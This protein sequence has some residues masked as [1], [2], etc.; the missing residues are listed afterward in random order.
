[1]H[2]IDDSTPGVLNFSEAHYSVCESE[3]KITIT[4]TRQHGGN[5]TVSVK[6]KTVDREAV[7]PEDYE[8][9]DEDEPLVRVSH[10]IKGFPL[11]RCGILCMSCASCPDLAL[12]LSLKVLEF[13][14]GD[15][16]KT[17]DIAVVDDRAYEKDESFDV[18]LFDPEGGASLKDTTYEH[19]EVAANVVIISDEK[20]RK[21]VDRMAQFFAL[22]YGAQLLQY[23]P[24]ASVVVVLVVTLNWCNVAQAKS[25]SVAPSI[26]SSGSRSFF[27][28]GT[29]S[30]RHRRECGFSTFLPCRGDSSLRSSR[31]LTSGTAGPRFSLP[32]W[33]L[34]GKFQSRCQGCLSRHWVMF[35]CASGCHF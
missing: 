2:I 29:A 21:V 4:V 6:V 17:F 34:L 24:G 7:S 28:G 30:A 25:E 35:G 27:R 9:I 1:M 5:G 11:D 23:T 3:K 10:N 20:E 15:T 19:E 31:Q 26:R 14:P 12:S 8:G 16:F 33:G 13:A 32:C 18:V 22:N